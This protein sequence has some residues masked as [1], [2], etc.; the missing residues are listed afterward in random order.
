MKCKFCGKP[1]YE[2][3]PTPG[4]GG[5]LVHMRGRYLHVKNDE[6]RCGWLPANAPKP[7]CHICGVEAPP[8]GM[9]CSA[10]G[11]P[12]AAA[13]PEHGPESEPKKE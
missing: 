8:H 11:P 2:T 3:E 5:R 1:I 12:V 9:I 4:V 13:T 10:C 6:Y 7:K